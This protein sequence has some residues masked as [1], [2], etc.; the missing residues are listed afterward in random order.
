[1]ITDKDLREVLAHGS[2]VFPV[3]SYFFTGEKEDP[4]PLHWHPEVEIALFDSGEFPIKVN[5]KDYQVTGPA[6]LVIPGNSLHSMH[7]DK[8]T[9]EQ[10][11]VFDPAAIALQNFDEIEAEIL[12]VLGSG[13]MPPPPV[14]TRE[15]GSF[16]T[17]YRLV[18]DISLHTKDPSPAARLLIKAQLLELLTHF[19]AEGILRRKELPQNKD[20][21]AQQNRVKDILTYINN[22]YAGPLTLADVA[23]RLGVSEPYFCRF[24]RKTTDMSFTE[25]LNALRLRKAAAELKVSDRS[26]TDIALDH[27]FENVGYFF[28][29]FKA[30]YGMTPVNFRKQLL[31]QKQ[32]KIV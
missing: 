4:V 24:F 12:D 27:G 31:A 10:A 19:Y 3:A 18:K 25:Y 20:N 21:R 13:H 29:L 32:D 30:R 1:M 9:K 14:M 15:Y 5:M 8:G 17:C 6:I 7:L 26:V 2:K 23:T 28:K 16:D 11:I 22:H